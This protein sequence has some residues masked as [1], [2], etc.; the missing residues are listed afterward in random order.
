M[1]QEQNMVEQKEAYAVPKLSGGLLSRVLRVFSPRN[2]AS[3]SYRYLARQLDNDLAGL[4]EAGRTVVLGSPGAMRV[5]TESLLLF[6]YFLRDELGSKVL[7]VDATFRNDGIGARLGHSGKRGFMDLLYESD[8]TVDALIQPTNRRGIHILPAGNPPSDGFLPLKS[9]SL[10][11]V[12][13]TVQERFDYVLIQ[14]GSILKDTRYLLLAP[15]VDVMFL[16]VEEGVTRMRDL[17][18]CQ[19]LL[20]DNHVKNY[21]FVISRSS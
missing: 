9:E 15:L 5:N 20:R 14:Q 8:K 3:R 4:G 11:P 6:A 18:D 19:D 10:S 2:P 7:L 1:N 17:E 16:V 21:K 12:L 13:E